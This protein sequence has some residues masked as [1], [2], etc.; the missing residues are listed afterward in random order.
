MC[1]VGIAGLAES[2]RD[3]ECVQCAKVHTG[4]CRKK[5]GEKMNEKRE[6]FNINTVADFEK[7]IEQLNWRWKIEYYAYLSTWEAIFV[8]QITKKIEIIY[9]EDVMWG[10][11]KAVEELEKLGIL[12]IVVIS[13]T[14]GKT[15]LTSDIS[16]LFKPKCITVSIRDD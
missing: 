12:K 7:V 16:R 3:R 8:N 1:G 11:L 6:V 5:G 9:K 15:T 14:V 4:M 13:W 10:I 2:Q